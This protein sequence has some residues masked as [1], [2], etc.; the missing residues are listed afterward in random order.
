MNIFVLSTGRCGSTTFARACSHIE[1]YSC[2]HESQRGNLH[3]DYPED[4]IESDPSLSRILG[5][6]EETYGDEA[7]YVHLIRNKEDTVQSLLRHSPTTSKAHGELI[8]AYNRDKAIKEGPTL[9]EITY[10]YY[11]NVNRNIKNFLKNKN[12]KFKFSL[13]SAKSNFEKFWSEI[14]AIGDLRK[15][16]NQWDKTY[17]AY[18]PNKD[19]G[20]SIPSMPMRTIKKVGR[21]LKKLPLFMRQA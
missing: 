10:D 14:G 4:H 8:G 21:I 15:A 12:K 1:N 9:E 6:L 19:P 17:N 7:F 5:W 18:D 13:E 20:N 2:A 11:E 16:T 3:R